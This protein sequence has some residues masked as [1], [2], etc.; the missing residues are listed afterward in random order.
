MLTDL[1]FLPVHVSEIHMIKL[2]QLLSLILCPPQHGSYFY[3]VKI[4]PTLVS[5][6]PSIYRKAPQTDSL[7]FP[8][9]SYT[10]YWRYV[11]IL[12]YVSGCKQ[13]T[14]LHHITQTVNLTQAAYAHP[15][16]QVAKT[17]G[18]WDEPKRTMETYLYERERLGHTD[19]TCRRG[20][21]EMEKQESDKELS[22][23]PVLLFGG[24]PN[25]W[26]WCES[27]WSSGRLYLRL[28]V[29]LFDIRVRLGTGES[30][31]MQRGFS[32]F[33]TVVS[34]EN[35]RKTAFQKLQELDVVFKSLASTV[36][37]WTPSTPLWPSVRSQTLRRCWNHWWVSCVASQFYP[38][39]AE[40][41]KVIVLVGF[42]ELKILKDQLSQWLSAAFMC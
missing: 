27:G 19:G 9:Y 37:F 28:G 26:G 31:L 8:T 41:K 5:T 24:G 10:S 4:K 11:W 33:W 25:M 3:L 35:K 7:F 1:A 15:S 13:I 34:S 42:I 16:E 36:Y 21:S 22:S 40:Q 6:Q 32:N 39:P 17:N 20:L 18:P 29:S 12:F 23:V 38:H 2:L 14:A 30:H